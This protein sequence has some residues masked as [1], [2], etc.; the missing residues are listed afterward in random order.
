MAPRFVSFVEF[1]DGFLLAIEPG[2]FE[3]TWIDLESCWHAPLAWKYNPGLDVPHH[4]CTDA[5]AETEFDF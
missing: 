2:K 3:I 1:E 4:R 5:W